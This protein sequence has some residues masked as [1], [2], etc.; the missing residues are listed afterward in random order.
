MFRAYRPPPI[1]PESMVLAI[2]ELTLMQCG[3]IRGIR[4]PI[5][6]SLLA[7]APPSRRS[8]AIDVILAD[9]GN[10][11]EDAALAAALRPLPTSCSRP[12]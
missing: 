11:A 9:K 6:E 7:L 2:D 3:G 12:N 1:Q 10:P 4:R 8:V 5:A